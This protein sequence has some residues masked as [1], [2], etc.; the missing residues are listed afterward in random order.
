MS[1]VFLGG[2]VTG[3]NPLYGWRGKLIPLLNIDYFN[4][5]VKNWNKEAINEEYRQKYKV[6]DYN[7]FVITPE[8]RG[9]L[10]I[11]EAADMVNKNPEGTVFCVLNTTFE[12][13]RKFTAQQLKSLDNVGDLIK[14]N[15]GKYFKS[16]KDVAE[17]LNSKGA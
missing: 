7:L 17:Y 11:A 13:D 3:C 10:S 16:L 1:K 4:P 12:N 5:V 9:Y 2:T 8:L 6:C 14:R 15:G